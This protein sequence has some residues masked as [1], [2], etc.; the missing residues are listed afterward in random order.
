MCGLL[1]CQTPGNYRSEAEEHF[2]SI[3][4]GNKDRLRFGVSKTLPDGTICV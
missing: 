3:M 4:P 1:H 2:K